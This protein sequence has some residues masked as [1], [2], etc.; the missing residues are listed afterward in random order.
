MK[1]L[2]FTFGDFDCLDQT[3]LHLIKEMRKIVV[4]NKEVVVV[5]LD[6]YGSFVNTNKFPIQDLYRRANNLSFFVKDIRQCSSPDPS[7]YFLAIIIKAKE[8]GLQP[9]FVIYDDNKDFT[10]RN[11]L[12]DNNVPVRF[13]KKPIRI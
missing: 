13:I 9:I 2:A 10:G 5:L 3:H 4:P 1:K 8:A 7:A 6:D 12:K 11:T